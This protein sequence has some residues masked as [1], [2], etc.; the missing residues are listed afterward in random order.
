MLRSG[1]A[2]RDVDETLELS[3]WGVNMNTELTSRDAKVSSKTRVE[4]P[5]KGS[6]ERVPGPPFA[7]ITNNEEHVAP[8]RRIT[9]S[10]RSLRRALQSS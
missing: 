2:A 6:R 4:A 1:V 5:E 7:A 3:A 9:L 8:C 10:A